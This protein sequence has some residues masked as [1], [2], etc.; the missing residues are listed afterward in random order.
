MC[1]ANISLIIYGKSLSTCPGGELKPNQTWVVTRYC[2]G[3][4]YLKIFPIPRAYPFS[5]PLFMDFGARRLQHTRLRGQYSNH[6]LYSY[7][8]LFPAGR[9]VH[10]LAPHAYSWCR[11]VFSGTTALETGEVEVV[12]RG[13]DGSLRFTHVISSNRVSFGSCLR[14]PPTSR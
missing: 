9:Y 2:S 12:L 5:A 6:H 1:V 4:I 3:K 8:R 14:P 13:R 10:W 11:H 7:H